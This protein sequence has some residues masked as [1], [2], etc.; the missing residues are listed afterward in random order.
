MRLQRLMTVAMTLVGLMMGQGISPEPVGAQSATP[1]EDPFGAP[2]AA[3]DRLLEQLWN[4]TFRLGATGI[5][6]GTVN[7]GDNNASE[8]NTAD[9]NWSVDL[10][11]GAPIGQSGQAV[12]LIEAAQ[13]DGLTDEVGVGNAL[14]GVNDDAG[15]SK[16]RLEVMEVWYE[17]KLWDDHTTFTLGKVDLTNYFDGNAVANDETT[18]FL[19]TGLV[20]SIAVEFPDDNG[21]GAR[22]TV[23]PTPWLDLSAGWAEADADYEDVFEDGF[24]ILEIDLKPTIGTR[25]GTYRFY[26]WRN[27]G[28]HMPFN[29]P[30]SPTDANWGV[31]IS[32][33][34]QLLEPLTVFFRWGIQDEDVSV[35][36]AAWSAGLES[37]G[38]WWGRPNDVVAVAVGQAF[39]SSTF[40]HSVEAP[41]NT[42]DELFIEAYYRVVFNAYLA[43]SAH[44]QVIDNPGGDAALDTVTVLGGRVQ[45]NF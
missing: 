8:G 43:F 14:F 10:E 39:L 16:A 18:Q 38:L 20:N 29:D 22:L 41:T 9:A 5:I 31:G 3:I 23:S 45:L 6:Q 40:A 13:G 36:K 4:L 15:D 42:A 12:I 17:H 11:V 44:L 24:A 28:D 26:V 19:A 35:I 30:T 1:H 2:R 7:N 25:P 27:W 33:D 32:L 37:R 34:Q 21:A